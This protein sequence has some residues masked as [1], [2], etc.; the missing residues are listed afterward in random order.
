M[1][2]NTAAL[3][4]FKIALVGTIGFGV[5]GVAASVPALDLPWR[6]FTDLA[7]WP[8][9]GDPASFDVHHRMFSAISG[10]L[11]I[12]LATLLLW[13]ANGPLARGDSDARKAAI[14]ALLAWYSTD[15]LGSI[16]AG[17]PFNM[18]LNT[19]FLVLLV[20]PLLMMRSSS[21]T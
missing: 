10:G 12:G 11:T 2:N 13:M 5:L 18:A 9:D 3:T 14:T 20:A 21:A 7:T 19:L 8:L 15:S 4:L 17:A 6:L 16:I 1:T